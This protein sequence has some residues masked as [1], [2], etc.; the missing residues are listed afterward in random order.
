[1]VVEEDE[2]LTRGVLHILDD[3]GVWFVLRRQYLGDDDDIGDDGH[4]HRYGNDIVAV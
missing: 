3:L 1:M 4:G 2:Q